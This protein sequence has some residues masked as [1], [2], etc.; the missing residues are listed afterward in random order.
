MTVDDAILN[1][2]NKYGKLIK[3]KE[4][5]AHVLSRLNN[6]DMTLEILSATNIGRYVNRCVDCY[7][8]TVGR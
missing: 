3:K 7:S 1:K 4:K 8:F 5:V 2:V 6:I